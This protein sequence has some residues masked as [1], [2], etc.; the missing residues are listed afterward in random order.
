M[1]DIKLIREQKEAVL[2]SMEHRGD[3]EKKKL[4]QDVARKD[5]LYRTSL[6][7]LEQMKRQRNEA[8]LEIAKAKKAGKDAAPTI[9]K[10]K[11]LGDE[12]IAAEKETERMKADIDAALMR[13]PNMLHESVPE[14]VGEE[15][16]VVIK[17]W[18]TP[19]KFAFAPKSHVD[20]LERLEL[21]DMERA[22]KVA[23]ARFYY[24]KGPLVLLEMALMRFALDHL[25]KKG[26]TP[27]EPPF[28]MRRGAYEGVTDLADF[29]SVIYKVQDED[30]YLIATS[31]HPMASMYMGETLPESALPVRFAGVSPCFRKEAGA[32]GKDTKGIFRVHQFN[33]VEQFVFCKPEESW[34]EFE[35]IV[36][37]VSELFQ[38]LELPYRLVNVCTGDIGS[39]AA[40]KTDLEVWMP[41]QGAYREA[42]SCSN[43]TDYQ[44]RRLGIRYGVE[45]EKPR[46]FVHTLNATAVATTRALVAIMENCQVQDGGFAIPAALQ[47]YMGGMKKI[48]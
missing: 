47:P 46:G 4:V 30:L 39:V 26:F 41:V 9:K 29:E 27:V 23:G 19:K 33:K 14:G 18:G 24:L 37:N 21:A 31:E 17:K 25:V 8:G 5:E 40:K 45:G 7:N 42:A 13:L 20:M 35:G 38:R 2:K 6:Y 11:R 3:A 34:K 12:I 22:G 43:C 36:Q 1:F 15:G 44:A 48:G 10:M 28:M 32:H 16:N